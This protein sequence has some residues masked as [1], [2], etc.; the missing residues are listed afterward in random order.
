[1]LQNM[2]KMKQILMHHSLKIR[3]SSWNGVDDVCIMGHRIWPAD[4]D[5]MMSGSDKV[6]DTLIIWPR[7]VVATASRMRGLKIYQLILSE[8]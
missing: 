4:D 1:M 6:D 8:S 2:I 5:E 3:S 7:S